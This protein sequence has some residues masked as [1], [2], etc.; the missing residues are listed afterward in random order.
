MQSG[1]KKKWSVGEL[2]WESLYQRL[3]A[4]KHTRG[5]CVVPKT[6]REDPQL[7]HW[8][9][10]IRAIGNRGSRPSAVN[11]PT[12][13]PL[14]NVGEVEH[15]TTTTAAAVAYDSTIILPDDTAVMFE[16]AVDIAAEAAEEPI[17]GSGERGDSNLPAND[18]FHLSNERREKLDS[19]GFVWNLRTRR[20]DDHWDEMF[21]K[22]RLRCCAR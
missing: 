20:I 21:R 19:L 16:S 11:H 17:G 13:S 22:V 8:V 7:A 10:R 3:V 18:A 2:E 1:R 4:F 6:Y 15:E 5:H 9:G 12:P 14:V